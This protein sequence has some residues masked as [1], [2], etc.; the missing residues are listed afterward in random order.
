MRLIADRMLKGLADRLRLIGY[1]CA[2]VPEDARSL[3]AI[4]KIA[5]AEGRM[6]VT[7]SRREDAH[8]EDVITVPPEQLSAQAKVVIDRI[9][10]DFDTLAFTRCSLDNTSL[11]FFSFEAMQEQLPPLVREMRPDP[12]SRCPQCGK[13]YWPGTHTKRVWDELTQWRNEIRL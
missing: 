10:I 7:S 9:P 2:M 8:T 5:R 3:A 11:E 4:V 12:V 13:V 6:L 1:D